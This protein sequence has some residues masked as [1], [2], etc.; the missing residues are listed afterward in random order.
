MH[1]R[2]EFKNDVSNSATQDSIMNVHNKTQLTHARINCILKDSSCDTSLLKI[3]KLTILASNASS[4]STKFR[5]QMQ[6]SLSQRRTQYMLSPIG[7]PV[8]SNQQLFQLTQDQKGLFKACNGAKCKDRLADQVSES[9][10]LFGEL[11]RVLLKD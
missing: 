9:P 3:L 6:R 11:S 1:L 4:S 2:I 8:F 7:L 5:N 10:N